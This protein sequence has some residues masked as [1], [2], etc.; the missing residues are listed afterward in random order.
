[1]WS[2][3]NYVYRWEAPRRQREQIGFK[4]KLPANAK[5][6]F[7]KEQEIL[8]FIVSITSFANRNTSRKTDVIDV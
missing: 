4:I 7:I 8:S 3:M 6:T 5:R 1:M 2:M